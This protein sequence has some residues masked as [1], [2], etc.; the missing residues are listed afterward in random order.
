MVKLRVKFWALIACDILLAEYTS[1]IRFA[2]NVHC[3]LYSL[4]YHSFESLK[5]YIRYYLFVS[6]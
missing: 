5:D 6:V 4:M 2:L 3:D 1:L